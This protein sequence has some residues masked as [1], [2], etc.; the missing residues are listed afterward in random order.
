MKYSLIVGCLIT[1]IYLHGM[2]GSNRVPD[3]NACM[4]G[5]YQKQLNGNYIKLSHDTWYKEIHNGHIVQPVAEKS[6]VPPLTSFAIIVSGFSTGMMSLGIGTFGLP[7]LGI[8][9]IALASSLLIRHQYSKQLSPEEKKEV[10]NEGC[11]TAGL[12][13]LIGVLSNFKIP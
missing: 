10:W 2:D 8:S 9:S 3:Q 4:P 11:T 5:L 7:L 12:F 6:M 1:Q 13:F